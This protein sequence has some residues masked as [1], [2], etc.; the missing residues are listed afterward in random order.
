[1][2]NKVTVFLRGGLGNQMFQYATGL[3]VAKKNDAPLVLD[4]VHL[5]DRFPR[6]HFTYRTYDLD[7]FTLGVP[8]FTGLSRAAKA[9][10]IPGVWLG[11][12][13]LGI[14]LGQAV[15]SEKVV[16]EKNYLFDRNVVSAR[17]NV[18]LYGR[19]QSEKYFA[20]IADEVRAAFRFRHPFEGEAKALAEKIR[21]S[22][23]VSLHV[24]R[25]DYAAFKNVA[26]IM[27][28]TNLGYYAAAARYVA[29]HARAGG[30]EPARDPHFFIFSDDIAWCKE[31][32]KLAFPATYVSA[33]SEGPKASW[34]M[35]LMSLCRHNI[36]TN[37]TF[38]WWGAWLNNNPQKIVVAPKHWLT[39][40]NGDDKDI[41]PERWIR[42]G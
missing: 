10:P 3:N 36:I 37:S 16:R 27:G 7:V 13:M 20:E 15:G 4:T 26:A 2:A 32:I 41:V 25:G 12:D 23:S 21:G 1:M 28:E 9:V 5:S 24:R 31:N 14:G 11:L 29:E 38:S 40:G 34:H 18:L 8:R 6:P 39:D 33:T 42:L 30:G 17:G 19:W 35:E 22:N